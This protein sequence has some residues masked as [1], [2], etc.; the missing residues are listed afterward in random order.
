MTPSPDHHERFRE[1]NDRQWEAFERGEVTPAQVRVRRWEQ[2]LDE[3]DARADPA[4]VSDAYVDHLAERSDLVDGATRVVAALAERCRVG[5]ITNGFGD[6]QRRRLAGTGL[7]DH[8]EVLVISDE[9]G[10]AKPDRA[11]F[12]AAFDRMGD[13]A[14]DAVAIVGDSLRSD[15]AGGLAYGIDTVW[16]NPSGRPRPAEPAPTAE[17]AAL[18]DLLEL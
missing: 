10:A 16:F 3:L 15:V 12:D 1:L 11:I 2:L 9:V 6:V 5:L 17:I 14:R 13:P 8:A 4:A 18:D 7:D